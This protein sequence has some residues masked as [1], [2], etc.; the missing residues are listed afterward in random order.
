MDTCH[1]QISLCKGQYQQAVFCVH[2]LFAGAPAP[3]GSENDGD[4][5]EKADEWGVTVWQSNSGR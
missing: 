2:V 1:C 4:A 3:A 5:L